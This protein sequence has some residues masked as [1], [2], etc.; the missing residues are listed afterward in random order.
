MTLSA[1][2]R[3]AEK[4]SQRGLSAYAQRCDGAWLAIKS[5]TRV[6]S[7]PQY[8][9]L[10]EVVLV[11]LLLVVVAGISSGR[12]GQ[13]RCTLLRRLE[14]RK[15]KPTNALDEIPKKTRGPASLREEQHDS[16]PW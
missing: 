5:S 2:V 7:T 1:L 16:P 3:G 9:V 13:L 11:V 6:H 15:H 14:E 10:Q 8:T 12:N 4:V